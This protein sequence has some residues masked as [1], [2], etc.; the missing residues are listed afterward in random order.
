LRCKPLTGIILKVVSPA[1]NL[2]AF[3]IYW[4]SIMS[5][6]SASDAQSHLPPNQSLF[7]FTPDEKKS[8]TSWPSWL[9]LPKFFQ[10]SLKASA[11]VDLNAVAGEIN[12]RIFG[13]SITDLEHGLYGGIW[14]EDS[15]KLRPDTLTFIKDLKPP[16]IRWAFTGNAQGQGSP[17]KHIGAEEVLTL[18]QETRAE[19]YFVIDPAASTPEEAAQQAATWVNTQAPAAS[20]LP[21]RRGVRLW[22]IAS[23]P[24]AIQPEEYAAQL[25]R[26]A[27]V[28]RAAAPEIEIVASGRAI[29]TDSPNDPARLWNETLLREAGDQVNFLAIQS[30][31]PDQGA[32][33]ANMDSEALYHAVCTAPLDVE[34][35]I[36]RVSG[37][38]KTQAAGRKIS[39]AVDA[40]NLQSAP[41]SESSSPYQVNYTMRDALYTAGVLHTFI[42]QCRLVSLANLSYLVNAFPLIITAERRSFTTPIYHPFLMYH[43]MEK[44][45]LKVEMIDC[46]TFNS[47]ALGKGAGHTGVN[48]IDMVASRSPDRQRIVLGII[49]RHMEKRVLFRVRLRNSEAKRPVRGF[50]L[51]SKSPLDFNSLE[52]PQAVSSREVK[53]PSIRSRDQVLLDLPPASVSIMVLE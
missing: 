1:Q 3:P 26:F 50:L 21:E 23:Q 29:L 36:Q 32:W 7:A 37:Q 17:H 18:C 31:Q 51:D 24:N 19:P 44:V 34:K 5:G 15:E 38:I 22:G 13:Q 41:I 16:V 43:R 8:G 35:V 2:S 9:R 53:M 27:S 28:M 30:F 6:I 42:R 46:P 20:G 12:P 10:R 14:S 52:T 25:K 45:A 4:R 33:P 39:I 40:W 49:N 48:Y 11:V 47:Q